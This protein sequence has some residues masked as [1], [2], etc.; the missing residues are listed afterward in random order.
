MK[1]IHGHLHLTTQIHDDNMNLPDDKYDLEDITFDTEDL[2]D[3]TQCSR[4]DLY[5]GD[6]LFCEECLE[7]YCVHC[8][9]ISESMRFCHPAWPCPRCALPVYTE[10]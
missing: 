10:M 3:C 7:E 1:T 2:F 4:K 8:D 5:I 9:I 6:L